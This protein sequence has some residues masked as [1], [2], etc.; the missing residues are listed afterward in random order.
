M[1]RDY[2]SR[3]TGRFVPT[4]SVTVALLEENLP[5]AY[6]VADPKIRAAAGLYDVTSPRSSIVMIASTAVSKIARRRASLSRSAS[7]AW[8][9]SLTSRTI[10]VFERMGFP[11]I[12]NRLLRETVARTVTIRQ[13]C[14]LKG[15]D[16][17]KV[18]GRILTADVL[19]AHNTFDKPDVVKPAVFKNASVSGGAL[20]VDL[21]PHSVV[22]LS[23]TK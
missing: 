13:A 6:G 20:K 19:D 1:D 9:R 23:L 15:I 5:V 21:P 22:V 10:A 3:R 7:S 8:R 18:A 11:A 14:A 17:K 4:T 2:L 16:A 12:T